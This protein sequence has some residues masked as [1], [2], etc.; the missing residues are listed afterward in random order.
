MGT[1]VEAISKDGIDEVVEQVRCR[2]TASP[3]G[4]LRLGRAAFRAPLPDLGLHEPEVEQ[5]EKTSTAVRSRTAPVL[6][7]RILRAVRE[8]VGDRMAITAKM[9]MTDGVRGGSPGRGEHRVRQDLRSAKASSTRSSS[10][11]EGRR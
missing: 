8:A 6:A 4:G 2:R 5:D 10:P 9:N 3:G 1:R 11:A 7:T